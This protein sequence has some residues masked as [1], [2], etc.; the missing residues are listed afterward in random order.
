MN[1]SLLKWYAALLALIW[2]VFVMALGVSL[3]ALF[4]FGIVELAL[5]AVGAA[6]MLK[7]SLSLYG[8]YRWFTGGIEE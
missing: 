8:A 7:G 3:L 5:G 2:G 6:A 4:F 1:W